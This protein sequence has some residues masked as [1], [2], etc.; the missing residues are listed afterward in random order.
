MHSFAG[1]DLID[2]DMQP[3]QK[4]PQ[5]EKFYPERQCN[6]ETGVRSDSDSCFASL[7]SLSLETIK[8]PRTQRLVIAKRKQ[9]IL[10]KTKEHNKWE[11]RTRR[12]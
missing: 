4:F 10:S 5:T 11:F 3:G 12:T 1:K 9:E 8:G 2:N 7:S 6:K